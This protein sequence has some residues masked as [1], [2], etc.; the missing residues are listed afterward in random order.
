[1]SE[2]DVASILESARNA[3]TVKA[4]SD[5]DDKPMGLLEIARKSR[6]QPKRPEPQQRPMQ[7]Q[8]EDEPGV[9]DFIMGLPAAGP[10]QIAGFAQNTIEAGAALLKGEDVDPIKDILMKPVSIEQGIDAATGLAAGGVVAPTAEMIAMVP[11][12]LVAL[13][14]ATGK[15]VMGNDPNMGFPDYF[16][17]SLNWM[18]ERFHDNVTKHLI[19]IAPGKDSGEGEAAYEAMGEFFEAGLNKAAAGGV[20]AAQKTVK[21]WYELTGGQW[22]P[23]IDAGFFA[24]TKG[25][26]AAAFVGLTA[27]S[28]PRRT[29]WGENRFSAQTKMEL[30][31]ADFKQAIN[32]AAYERHILEVEGL[33]AQR[34]A[35][36]AARLGEQHLEQMAGLKIWEDYSPIR[37][38]GTVPEKAA[39]KL[40]KRS[41]KKLKKQ[42][43]RLE[44]W[45]AESKG[46]RFAADTAKRQAAL[47]KINAIF[48]A[49]EAGPPTHRLALPKPE[50]VLGTRDRDLTKA[51]AET[52]TRGTVMV[53]SEAGTVELTLS[54]LPEQAIAGPWQAPSLSWWN[55]HVGL[56]ETHYDSFVAQI[57]SLN[58]A[59]AEFQRF[60]QSVTN[61][62]KMEAI[63]RSKMDQ[64]YREMHQQV[65]NT[66]DNLMRQEIGRGATPERAAQMA[67]GKLRLEA[68]FKQTHAMELEGALIKLKRNTELVPPPQKEGPYTSRHTPAE[69]LPSKHQTLFDQFTLGERISLLRELTAAEDALKGQKGALYHGLDYGALLDI[70]AREEGAGG[71]QAARKGV[72][73]PYGRFY[74]PEEVALIRQMT[75]RLPEGAL[76]VSL[77]DTDYVGEQYRATQKWG[78]VFDSY[79]RELERH[80][81]LEH[82]RRAHTMAEAGMKKGRDE[83]TPF[84][85]TLVEPELGIV[86]G[87]RAEPAPYQ[88]VDAPPS[89]KQVNIWKVRRLQ[90]QAR[91]MGL[92]WAKAFEG[93]NYMWQREVPTSGKELDRVYTPYDK[94]LLETEQ[95]FREQE[96]RSGKV[97]GRE[98]EEFVLEETASGIAERYAHEQQMAASEAAK[99]MRAPHSETLAQLVAISKGGGIKSLRWLLTNASDALVVTIAK[100]LGVKLTSPIKGRPKGARE[101]DF[102]QRASIRTLVNRIVA[103]DKGRSTDL[104]KAHDPMR[105]KPR[106]AGE[107]TI[108]E[109]PEGWIM[110]EGWI[111]SAKI[112]DLGRRK[113]PKGK[114]SVEDF[115]ARGGKV[116]KL[117]ELTPEELADYHAGRGDGRAVERKWGEE[118]ISEEPTSLAEQ[119]ARAEILEQENM[120]LAE[121]DVLAADKPM[122][123][124]KERRRFVKSEL[125]RRRGEIADKKT[126]K[127]KVTREANLEFDKWLT[128]EKEKFPKAE[129]D[130]VNKRIKGPKDQAGFIE[131][132]DVFGIGKLLGR[133]WRKEMKDHAKANTPKGA[134]PKQHKGPVMVSGETKNL[135][136]YLG[137]IF[138][139]RR[140]STGLLDRMRL[141]DRETG[142]AK[143][144]A[145][146][147]SLFDYI[148]FRDWRPEYGAMSTHHQLLQQLRG[149]YVTGSHVK[150]SFANLVAKHTGQWFW[151][152]R[153]WL[154][155]AVGGTRHG[156]TKGQQVAIRRGL[157]GLR[158]APEYRALVKDARKMYN[159]MYKEA[160]STGEA[161]P[162]RRD[163]LPF[164]LARRSWWD[165]RRN[166]WYEGFREALMTEARVDR[167][168]ADN[169]IANLTQNDGFLRAHMVDLQAIAHGD[170]VQR[171]QMAEI[172]KMRAVL[173]KLKPETLDRFADPD[174]IGTTMKYTNQVI[175]HIASNRRFGP[176]MEKANAILQRAIKEAS[177]AGVPFTKE[178]IKDVADMI[179]IANKA[180]ADAPS[181]IKSVYKHAIGVLNFALLGL[182]VPASLIEAFNPLR[183]PAMRRAYFE[184][185]ARTAVMAPIRGL[186]RQVYRARPNQRGLGA[187]PEEVIV[188]QAIG[189][190]ITIRDMELATARHGAD[191]GSKY[192]NAAFV[193]N[194]LHALTQYYTQAN[195]RVFQKSFERLVANEKAIRQGRKKRTKRHDYNKDM[196]ESY[197]INLDA[198]L[199]WQA[200]G[201]KK[202]GW[203]NSNYAPA[204][205]KFLDDN[206]LTARGVNQPKWH[207]NPNFAPLKHLMTYVTMFGNT[208]TPDVVHQLRGGLAR[209]H[210]L[211]PALWARNAAEMAAIGWVMYNMAMFTEAMMDEWKYGGTDYH[212]AFRKY[213][214]EDRG[215]R[216]GARAINRI[217]V[218]GFPL[219]KFYDLMEAA[220]YGGNKDFSQLLG[221]IGS[222]GWQLVQMIFAGTLDMTDGKNRVK[223]KH[224][225]KWIVHSTVP[226]ATALGRDEGSLGAD[227]LGSRRQMERDVE[228]WLR[229]LGM[230]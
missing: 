93:E 26:V 221:P 191:I 116:E 94:G 81:V 25:T 213:A 180:Y 175:G 224:V 177:D 160:A 9:L 161:A 128:V 110:E 126:S 24:A 10:A 151:E 133:V 16:T 72:V 225:A 23:E 124:K 27:R 12:G 38:A 172:R 8:Q 182:V 4:S 202:A 64:V 163:Y 28:L 83:I 208:I 41:R 209:H 92:R 206:V 30:D 166:K 150:G 146:L 96:K 203:W 51:P 40:T 60:M 68:F 127:A 32:E 115:M 137:Q 35:E 149:K 174:V 54:N 65:L 122:D 53:A 76:D 164:R 170:K 169:I 142:N 183:N 171:Q 2:R 44:A 154:P 47:D 101:A 112:K 91:E 196:F 19:N 157:Q 195:I 187:L 37:T 107:H 95:R 78:E 190:T 130:R 14:D 62:P 123:M 113:L 82:E 36:L 46:E 186:I 167:R 201:S 80:G 49:E 135:K 70:I 155:Y 84:P 178:N 33:K 223:T 98:H 197:G 179:N 59:T 139:G 11:M 58:A 114:E 111:Q 200:N 158:V 73:G 216:L 204:L 219:A 13:V 55:R 131:S 104:L 129:Q 198:A 48:A 210:R 61:T 185:Y 5:T 162:F 103:V 138:A 3:G 118:A 226:M 189:K 86:E 88:R 17:G 85:E 136:N 7:Q 45:L 144:T 205:I 193:I 215:G 121:A 77:R 119:A 39:T 145:T 173:S 147:F 152:M 120:R 50:D 134:E 6:Q 89:P 156:F 79:N 165:P 229:D 176:N 227:Y 188:G 56:P 87:F 97:R 218:G 105:V 90:R 75:D 211:H 207:S 66:Y 181:L 228:D 102:T 199:K 42:K 34:Q 192:G 230:D 15:T 31:M 21:P 168:T 217:G 222:K 22:T 18:S 100:E 214:P 57:D 71:A 194:G 106:A 29:Q 220:H 52:A 184:A 108:V 132:G 63:I 20:Y 143:W 43:A 67:A 212:P 141:I 74:T 125:R 148:P 140:A 117:A 1:M 153:N 159:N 99:A 109:A 69:G